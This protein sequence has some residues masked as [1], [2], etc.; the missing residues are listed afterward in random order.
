M[1]HDP[2]SETSPVIAYRAPGGDLWQVDDGPTLVMEFALVPEELPA[3][4]QALAGQG[5]LWEIVRR[6]FGVAP[7]SMTAEDAAEWGIWEPEKLARKFGLKPNDIEQELDRAIAFW[8]RERLLVTAPGEG[9][10][11]APAAE[12]PQLAAL[13]SARRQAE[14]LSQADIDELLLGHGFEDVTTE[15]ERRYVAAR[16]VELEHFLGDND[17]RGLA[18]Q[19]IRQELDLMYINAELSRER[20]RQKEGKTGGRT[21]VIGLIADRDKLQINYTKTLDSM[22]AT[23]AQS[24]SAAQR[25]S[26]QDSVGFLVRGYQEYYGKQ[27]NRLI[28]GMFTAAEVELMVRPVAERPSQYRPDVVVAVYHAR[29]TLWEKQFEGHRL[30]R[31]MSRKLLSFWK[32]FVLRAA[33][34]EGLE[35]RSLEA[36]IAEDA[37]EYDEEQGRHVP[38]APMAP[39]GDA[40]AP[41]WESAA[42]IAQARNTAAD[43][44]AAG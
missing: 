43:V 19:A 37:E 4:H 3:W 12:N 30:G 26:L 20:S 7:A 10:E 27:D 15:A 34:D 6:Y 11:E 18:L 32:D 35:V 2:D 41:V 9:E 33:E 16:I 17:G 25:V 22:G 40:G 38:A 29:Q 39:S 24:R 28:D 42:A 23:G 21:T 1:P 8:A 13:R 14:S 36:E 31:R 44:V 5:R